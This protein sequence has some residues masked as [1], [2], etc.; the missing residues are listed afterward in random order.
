MCNCTYTNACVILIEKMATLHELKI[1]WAD[2]EE[3][4]LK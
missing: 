3:K 2:N 1:L 4:F